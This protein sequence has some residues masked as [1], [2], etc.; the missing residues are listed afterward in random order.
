MHGERYCSHIGKQKMFGI[1]SYQL[2]SV[3]LMKHHERA[4]K[5]NLSSLTYLNAICFNTMHY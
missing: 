3:P 2:L 5:G 4:F 1:V